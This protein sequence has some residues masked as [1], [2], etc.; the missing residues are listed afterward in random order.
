MVRNVKQE[1]GGKIGRI[2]PPILKIF[3]RTPVWEIMDYFFTKNCVTQ[4][5]CWGFFPYRSICRRFFM[6]GSKGSGI[7][8]DW[9]IS[10]EH[11]TVG[12][13]YVACINSL[14]CFQH[15]PSRFYRSQKTKVRTKRRHRHITIFRQESATS[16]SPW[17][18]RRG[19]PSN[20]PIFKKGYLVK[21]RTAMFSWYVYERGNG[22]KFPVPCGISF[23]YS[24]YF[25]KICNFLVRV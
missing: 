22:W 21:S 13:S 2:W 5:T 10:C 6:R 1:G 11:V 23:Y 18:S 8:P 7:W 15:L 16:A 4:D 25:L 17:T 9:I 3:T 19:N 24:I 12:V 20:I 14:K